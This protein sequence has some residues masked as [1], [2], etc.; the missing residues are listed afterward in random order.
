MA[1]SEKPVETPVADD[2]AKDGKG[3]RVADYLTSPRKKRR[4]YVVLALGDSV[5]AQLG[6]GVE[7]FVRSNFKNYA[8]AMPRTPEELLK[9]FG[10]QIVM[11]VFD[12]EFTDL[13][14]GL[15][16]VRELKRRKSQVAIPVLFLT[17]NPETLIENY[18]RV[19][20]AYHETDD[21]LSLAR[22][23]PT[24]V[25][26]KIRLGLTTQNRRRSRRYHVDLEIKFKL[27]ADPDAQGQRQG[28]LLDLSVHGA[29]VKAE[30][31][32][33]FQPGMQ[34]KLQIPVT[35]YLPPSA[36]DYLRIAARVRRVFIDGNQA[37]IS[38]EHVNESQMLMVTQYLTEMVNDQNARRALALKARAAR[39]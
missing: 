14:A 26:S 15:E 34:M 2:K 20:G 37:G 30:D 12:D 8:V 19:L 23:E 25:Y 9:N 3:G 11:L 18:N 29:F 36:G 5:S 13:T 31:G 17:R 38:F 32:L 1:Q 6:S 39:S 16:L 33:I 10:R 35:G 22:A 21:Y 27:L 7:Y 24:H 4:N 28:R